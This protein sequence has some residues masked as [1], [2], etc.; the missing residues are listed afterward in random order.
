[1][2]AFKVGILQCL[3]ASSAQFEIPK[4]LVAKIIED[5]EFVK[6]RMNKY[7][8]VLQDRNK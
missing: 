5:L 2:S 4:N 3:N 8:I 7:S 1:M 6:D